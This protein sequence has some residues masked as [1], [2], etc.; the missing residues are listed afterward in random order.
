MMKRILTTN[1]ADDV[2]R[3]LDQIPYQFC[4]RSG[5]TRTGTDHYYIR[6][7]SGSVE[8]ASVTHNYSRGVY[9]VRLAME[10]R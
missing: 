8:V 10:R 6:T 9:N 4:G 7:G 2:R 5:D 3:I 1:S